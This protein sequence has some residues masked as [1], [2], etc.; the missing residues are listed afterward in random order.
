MPNI[1]HYIMEENK[2]DVVVVVAS[3]DEVPEK[4]KP[5][6]RRDR[7]EYMQNYYQKHKQAVSCPNCLR[8]FVCLRSLKHHNDRNIHCLVSR[9]EN[10][11]GTVR[12]KFPEEVGKVE[13]MLQEELNRIRKL[14]VK[15]D[16]R[17][18][19]LEKN[20]PSENEG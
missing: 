13:P 7:K 3:E 14:K 18:G 1:I 11:W 17:E 16:S 6:K 8:E 19:S 10:L 5:K 2:P 4:K 15:R 12:D 20:P 9:L